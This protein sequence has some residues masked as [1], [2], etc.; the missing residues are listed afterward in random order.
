MMILKMSDIPNLQ[1]DVFSIIISFTRGR[2]FCNMFS[3]CSLFRAI[4]RKRLNAVDKG[5]DITH[6]KNW[7]E[8]SDDTL[9][10][11]EYNLQDVPIMRL[12]NIIPHLSI[13]YSDAISYLLKHTNSPFDKLI[14]YKSYRNINLIDLW[15]DTFPTPNRYCV[16]LYETINNI[17]KI[18]IMSYFLERAQDERFTFDFNLKNCVLV[19]GGKKYR[20]AFGKPKEIDTFAKNYTNK[21]SNTILD[22]IKSIFKY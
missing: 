11:H 17:A 21:K 3:V 19:S 14:I 7:A 16:V 15:V 6:I 5:K 20:S 8:Y 1:K 18:K 10:I 9:I 4:C 2:D 13:Q 22:K 12:T